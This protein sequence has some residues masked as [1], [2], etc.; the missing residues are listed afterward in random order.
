M[1]SRILRWLISGSGK[2]TG[3]R[4][5]IPDLWSAEAFNE[6]LKKEKLRAERS[7]SPFVLLVFDVRC[8]SGKRDDCIR[9]LTYLAKLIQECT[10]ASD[11]RGWY[12]EDG[13]ERV[14]IILPDTFRKGALQV[15]E[16]VEASFKRHLLKVHSGDGDSMWLVYKMYWYPGNHNSSD[17]DD[18]RLGVNRAQSNE[19]RPGDSETQ[20]ADSQTSR[21]TMVPYNI[22]SCSFTT[23][24]NTEQL[25]NEVQIVHPGK[26]FQ[27]LAYHLPRWKRTVDI[28]GASLGLVVLSPIMFLVALLIKMTS[29]GPIFFRQE[30]V[31][32]LGKQ[33]Q[34]LKFRSMRT[35][36]DESIHQKHLKELICNGNGNGNGSD[37]PMTKIRNDPR[38]TKLGRLLRAWCL[39]ELPQLIHVLRGEMSLIGP[40]PPIQY[41][42]EDYQDWHKQRLNIVP[43]ITGLWQVN[44]KNAMTFD[45]MVRVDLRYMKNLSF[46]TDIKILAKTIPTVLRIGIGAK[47]TAS[48]Q[49]G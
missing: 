8:T 46:W 29:R 6:Q 48:C 47:S 26:L 1:P 39:D 4:S 15:V 30:R 12:R 19:N 45:E 35:H 16:K 34:F 24:L 42:V 7:N 43:G 41:E 18:S 10:R 32:Y 49:E 37:K 36:A 14:G 44:G 5:E 23:S 13:K 2:R 25:H 28:V 27:L 11:T 21:Q 38:V 33:F 9:S 22:E 40:R 20:D 31:G 3:I 17:R